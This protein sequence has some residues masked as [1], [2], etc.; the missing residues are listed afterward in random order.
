MSDAYAE[1]ESDVS[2]CAKI[3]SAPDSDGSNIDEEESDVRA[4]FGAIVLDRG[5]FPS[6]PLSFT[7]IPAVILN[8]NCWNLKSVLFRLN[9]YPTLPRTHAMQSDVEYS[10]MAWSN[11]SNERQ[12]TAYSYLHST[13]RRHLRAIVHFEA[14]RSRLSRKLR[15]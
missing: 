3:L 13:L 12:S 6:G 9:F 11:A 2:C 4:L 8:C 14:F 10:I 7:E 5:F 15:P 1:V